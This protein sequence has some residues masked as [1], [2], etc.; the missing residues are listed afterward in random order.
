MLSQ[1]AIGWLHWRQWERGHTT[2]SPKGSRR[3]HTLRKLPNSKPKTPKK[4]QGI[5]EHS[6][7]TWQVACRSIIV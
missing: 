4:T 1:L 6:S 2:D 5:A 3:M 7:R